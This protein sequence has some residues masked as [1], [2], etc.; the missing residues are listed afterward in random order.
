MVWMPTTIRSN[1]EL[2]INV[3]HDIAVHGPLQID[4][5]IDKTKIDELTL[6]KNLEFLVRNNLI[7]KRLSNK[8]QF[9]YTITSRG[10]TILN[11]FSKLNDALKLETNPLT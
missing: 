2:H 1:L 3:L 7:K 10:S 11:W 9:F 4:D 8:S 6:K 5:I